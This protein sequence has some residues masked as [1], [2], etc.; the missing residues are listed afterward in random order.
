MLAGTG[1][2]FGVSLFDAASLVTSTSSG[3]SAGSLGGSGRGLLRRLLH[4]GLLGEV[5]LEGHALA[6][7]SPPEEQARGVEAPR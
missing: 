3:V 6:V 2:R 4:G 5:A 7:A 1:Y